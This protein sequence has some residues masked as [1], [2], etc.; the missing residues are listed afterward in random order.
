MW[1]RRFRSTRKWST[2]MVTDRLNIF[3]C[4]REI[5]ADHVT[6]T[7]VLFHAVWSTMLI[8]FLPFFSNMIYVTKI[9]LYNSL[10]VPIALYDCEAWTMNGKHENKH[11]VFEMAALR[12][13]LGVSCRDK[14][15][16]VDIWERLGVKETLVQKIYLLKKH[17][18]GPCMA[19]EQRKNSQVCT[20]R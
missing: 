4:I 1:H 15:C 14:I 11:L 10:I 3:F 20:R 6:L 9:W 7:F 2:V 8:W 17:L 16:N 18:A 5:N 19:N 13:M 12:K